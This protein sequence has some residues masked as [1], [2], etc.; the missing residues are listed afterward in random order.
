MVEELKGEVKAMRDMWERFMT[1][2]SQRWEQN[3]QT[4]AE[5]KLMLK[6]LEEKTEEEEHGKSKN[7]KTLLHAK[8]ITPEKLG[9]AES[10]R[11][12]REDAEDYC[13]EIIGGMHPIQYKGDDQTLCAVEPEVVTVTT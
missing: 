13:E 9:K 10:W 3:M 7:K 12:W 6:M 5:L 11:T 4:I 1:M 8:S 2:Q